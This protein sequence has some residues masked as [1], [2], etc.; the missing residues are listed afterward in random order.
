[1]QREFEIQMKGEL[2]YFHGLQVKQMN[3]R[4]FLHQTK[5][6]KELLKKFDMDKSKEAATPTATNCYISAYEK[7]KLINQTKYRGIIGSL[8]YLTASRIGM[9]L[10]VCSLSIMS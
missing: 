1:M 9:C 2:K 10:H 5:Y 8:L 6:C 3:H 7:G 4:T